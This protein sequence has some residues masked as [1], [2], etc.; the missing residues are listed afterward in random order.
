MIKGLIS[1][2]LGAF[3]LLIIIVAVFALFAI[4]D[5]FENKISHTK[6]YKMIKS[7]TTI[8]CV[9]FSIGLLLFACWKM[10]NL[11]IS[12]IIGG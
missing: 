8:L 6:I 2:V 3:L 9:I 4:V 12:A 5:K 10:G 1:V 11:L 7:I